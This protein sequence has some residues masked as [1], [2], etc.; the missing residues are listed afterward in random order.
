MS[1]LNFSMAAAI[2][3][4]RAKSLIAAGASLVVVTRGIKGA[5][6][7]HRAAGPVKVRGT[8]DRRGGYDRCRRQLS[9]RAAVRLARRGADQA[10]SRWRNEC[11]TSFIARCRLRRLARPSHAAAPAPILRAAPMSVWNCL[12][13]FQTASSELR[14]NKR[15]HL[16]AEFVVIRQKSLPW[17]EAASTSG[18]NATVES[19]SGFPWGSR[20][21]SL[22]DA[23]RDR[24]RSD[25]R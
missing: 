7:W 11:R 25:R 10:R 23:H 12:I 13:S 9:G 8:H 20:R 1:I 18:L 4:E 15:R 22:G 19:G 5:Q 14:R 21:A 24:R 3:R 16:V 2:M 17:A 6:A